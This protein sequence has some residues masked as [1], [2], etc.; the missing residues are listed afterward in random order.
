[1]IQDTPQDSYSHSTVSVSHT[2]LKHIGNEL[3]VI[4][5]I[6]NNKYASTIFPSIQMYIF[7]MESYFLTKKNTCDETEY[8]GPMLKQ[9]FRFHP[10]YQSNKSPDRYLYQPKQ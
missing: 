1:M 2:Q 9:M 6:L 7:W 5:N 10:L 8:S 3:L 4:L